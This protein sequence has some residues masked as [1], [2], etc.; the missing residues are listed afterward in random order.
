MKISGLYVFVIIFI[1]N[2]L[3]AQIG[4]NATN[5]APAS[6]AI[7]DVSSISKGVL[8]P[9]MATVQRTAPG[10]VTSE[11]ITVYDTD[12]HSY[13]VHNGS[14]WREFGNGLWATFGSNIYSNN[15]GL[16]GIGT[17]S[18]TRGKFEVNGVAGIGNTAAIFGAFSNGISLQQNFPTIGF[19]QFRDGNTGFGRYM[20][21]GFASIQY[22]GTNSGSMYYDVFP[23]GIG[24]SQIGSAIN[25]YEIDNIGQVKINQRL[26]I[27]GTAEVVTPG[28]G[29][30]NNLLP[31]A[32]T[33]VQQI[34]TLSN[35]TD[36]IISSTWVIDH[37]EI[38]TNFSV[39]GTIPIITPIANASVTATTLL[40][41][42]TAIWVYLWDSSGETTQRP[43]NIVIF[44]P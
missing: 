19:N 38:N 28:A 13:W 43:F 5:S 26:V 14:S 33:S 42:P 7:L 18:P 37:Y 6:N 22:F 34:G 32:M 40:G 17:T 27:N 39:Q 30:L 11:G 8:L 21:N 31:F 23:T 16:V 12:T 36:N 35:S 24:G 3:Q 44:K 1:T 2:I 15:A 9:R 41:S 4:V 25:A 10:F 29:L 20:A